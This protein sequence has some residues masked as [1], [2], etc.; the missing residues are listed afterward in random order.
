MRCCD[1]LGRHLNGKQRKVQQRKEL[2]TVV[3]MPTIAL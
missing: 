3:T 1:V 2:P